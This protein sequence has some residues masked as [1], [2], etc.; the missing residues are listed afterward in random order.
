MKNK[1][2]NKKRERERERESERERGEKFSS[3][4]LAGAGHGHGLMWH[5]QAGTYACLRAWWSMSVRGKSTVWVWRRCY[6]CCQIASK[7][8]KT[9]TGSPTAFSSSLTPASIHERASTASMHGPPCLTAH[10]HPLLFF[11]FCF[12]I[13]GCVPPAR[14]CLQ[15]STGQTILP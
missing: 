1:N 10:P 12:L 7:E 13:F 8:I 6:C 3:H 9:Q 15:Q 5:G 2:K 4:S 11:C 14:P